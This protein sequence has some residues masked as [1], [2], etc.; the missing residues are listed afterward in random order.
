M[1]L[2]QLGSYASL[3]F[4]F[5]CH[6]AQAALPPAPAYKATLLHPPGSYLQSYATGTY[7]TTIVGAGRGP[8]TTDDSRAL[9]WNG[10]TSSIIDLTPFGFDRSFASDVW[11][12][13]QVG[14]IGSSTIVGH[15]VLWRGSPRGFIDLHLPGYYHTHASAVWGDYQV[16]YGR[17]LFE[18][19]DRALLWNGSAASAVNLHS[20][21][22]RHTRAFDVEGNTQVGLGA[23]DT[24]ELSTT[25]ALLWRGSAASFVDLHPAGFDHSVAT[26]ISGGRIS[27]YVQRDTPVRTNHALT[28]NATAEDFVDLHPIGFDSTFAQSISG[29]VQVGFGIGPATNHRDHALV[30]R[31]SADSVLNLHQYLTGLPITFIDSFASQVATNGM[32]VGSARD[33]NGLDYA[34]LWTPIPEPATAALVCCGLLLM[35]W[36]AQRRC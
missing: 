15:A 6:A 5:F 3:A 23:I 32:I 34:I 19:N 13:Y 27:G 29:D 22:F 36:R 24:Q 26:G 14:N 18:L 7:G 10:T 1:K 20:S 12:D 16:G 21:G 33:S 35:T 11:G 30:W 9:I 31:G 2:C 28:W 25:H 17:T 8:N 4:L